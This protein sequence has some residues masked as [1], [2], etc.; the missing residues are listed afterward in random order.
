MSSKQDTRE[1]PAD[2]SIVDEQGLLDRVDGS[3][4]LLREVVEL[5]LGSC[6]RQ[7]EEL[8]A[9]LARGESD[10]VA[11]IAHTIKGSVAFFAAGPVVEIARRLEGMGRRG[12]L[13]G[14][15]AI[16]AELDATLERLTGALAA[17]AGIA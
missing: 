14:A 6:P 7:R 4:E 2:L 3:R 11:R 17:F 16:G 15:E 5:F 13:A 10:E 12:E 8:R 1:T 9:A